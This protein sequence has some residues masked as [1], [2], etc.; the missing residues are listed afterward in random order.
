MIELREVAYKHSVDM[1][2]TETFSHE[3]ENFGHLAD[4]LSR[5]IFFMNQQGKI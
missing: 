3:S 2:A 4:R 1:F 5:R